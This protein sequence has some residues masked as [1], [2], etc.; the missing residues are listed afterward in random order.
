MST[1]TKIFIVLVCLFAFLFTPMVIQFVA[2]TYNWKALAET[3][4][5]VAVASQVHNRNLIALS[6][7]EKQARDDELTS[8]QAAF[9]RQTAELLKLQN[10]LAQSEATNADLAA[11]NRSLATSNELLSHVVDAKTAENTVLANTNKK[12]QSANDELMAKNSQLNDRVKELSAQVLIR[13]QKL[14]MAEEENIAIRQENER[15]RQIA[16]APPAVGPGPVGPPP[17]VEP[18]GP[19]PTAPIR[20]QVLDVQ[21]NSAEINVGSSDGVKKG[22]I[23]VVMREGKYLGDLRVEEVEPGNAVGTL[24]LTGQGEIRKGDNVT[25]KASLEGVR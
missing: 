22:M 13:E 11:K 14:R 7:A 21:G 18:I 17:G 20:G 19:A 2:Q 16:K 8:K 4:R 23:F 24:E 9:D 1:T 3:Y 5:E 6:A 25:D 12:L 10:Q 15:L